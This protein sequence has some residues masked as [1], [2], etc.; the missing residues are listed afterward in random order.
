MMDLPKSLTRQSMAGFS[1][2]ELSISL[3]VVGMIT[4]VALSVS[5]GRN[6]VEQVAH[7]SVA[8]QS[9]ASMKNAEDV[10]LGFAMRNER[11][12]CP[13]VDGDG[14]EDCTSLSNKVGTVPYLDI[15]LSQPFLDG[16]GNAVRYGVYRNSTAKADLTEKSNHMVPWLLKVDRRNDLEA[17]GG[18]DT[19]GAH[20]IHQNRMDFCRGLFNAMRSGS[21]SNQVYVRDSTAILNMAY[22]LVSGGVMDADGDGSHFDGQNAT[23]PSTF[24][25]TPD[26]RKSEEYDDIVK[27]MPFGVLAYRQGCYEAN[28]AMKALAMS[29]IAAENKYV[30]SVNSYK[31]AEFGV[32]TATYDRD[33]AIY[34]TVMAGIDVAVVLFDASITIAGIVKSNQSPLASLPGLAVT[35]TNVGYTIFSTADS[36]KGAIDGLA[37]AVEGRDAAIVTEQ[38][39]WDSLK[40]TWKDAAKMDEDEGIKR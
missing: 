14:R 12:P 4:A 16:N 13:D 10:V 25:E 2:V 19:T 33:S 18:D 21:S 37:G 39:T 5:T 35:A 27:V 3:A 29:T 8:K 9:M 7:R 31:N 24:F 26:R 38:E 30:A 1:L 17:A 20:A 23:A 36:L 6:A 40:V 11:L 22:I 32:K 28:M 34:G 15:G